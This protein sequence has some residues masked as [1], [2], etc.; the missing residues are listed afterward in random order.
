MSVLIKV[1]V[2]STLAREAIT[3]VM[4]IDERRR[5][6]QQARDYADSLSKPMLVVGAPKFTF[7]HPCGDVTIDINPGVPTSCDYEVADIRAIPYPSGHFAAA[8]ASHVLEHLPTIDDAILALN[9]LERVADKVFIVSPH[10]M[11]LAA[12]LHPSHHLWVTATGDGYLI[13]QRGNS[14]VREESYI[15]AMGVI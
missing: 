2:G 5:V 15:L 12:W 13:E 11:S 7:N 10:K 14:D 1:L 4:E 6:F 3:Q 8:Y 9:E